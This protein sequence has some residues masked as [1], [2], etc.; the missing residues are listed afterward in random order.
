MSFLTKRHSIIPNIRIREVGMNYSTLPNVTKHTVDGFTNLMLRA[1]NRPLKPRW[2]V[3]EV[4]DACNSRC[5]HCS[6]WRKEPT[7]DFLTCEE[8]KGVL[9]DDLFRNLESI[10]ITGGEPVLRHDLEE[11][12]MTMHNIRPEAKPY[13][14]TNGLLP[15]RVIEVL[16]YA[17]K[18]DIR[19]GVGISLDGIG[20]KHDLIRGVKGNFEK[21]DY[22]LHRLI[23]LRENCKDL[24]DLTIGFTLSS[25]TVDSFKETR[26][27][28]QRLNVG[29]L[30]Q[31]YADFPY[32]YKVQ[33]DFVND[34]LIETVKL[35]PNS[36]HHELWLKF[37]SGKSIK[38][39][40]FAMYSFCLLRCNGDMAPCLRFCDI[41]AGN[42]RED[43]PSVIW[44]SV[45]AKKARK[46]VKSCK[47]C[48]NDWGVNDSFQSYF[49]PILRFEV[50]KRL[51][52]RLT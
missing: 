8:L 34:R 2:L 15:Q 35:L 41:Q 10:L 4:T 46:L 50:M 39:P 36:P 26:A 52:L 17:I 44:H 25:L 31:M 23:A 6:I 5:K 33:G 29:F 43:S 47:G 21:T 49:L 51:R 32:Y 40:C 9:E 12:I 27:Y 42:V 45:A 3:Y 20:E 22:L 37:L 48:L 11:M 16:E 24:I 38:F 14:S 19:I 13:L 7:K 18:H 30:A 1:V 28:A